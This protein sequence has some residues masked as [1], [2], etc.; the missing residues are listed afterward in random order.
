MAFLLLH[1]LDGSGPGHWQNWIAERLRGR[2]LEVAFPSLPDAGNPHVDRWLVALDEE[3]DR[4]PAAETTVLCHSL[5]C[6][7]WLHHAAAGPAEPV[8]RT[9][10]VAPTQPDVDDPQ[11]PGFRP[12]PLDRRAVAAAARETLLVCSTDDP[13]GPPDVARRIAATLEV[14]I[15]WLEHAGH[16]NAAG[17]YGPWPA[18][19]AWAVGERDSPVEEA[20]VP[21]SRQT[22]DLER[23]V[24]AQDRDGTYAR[25]AAE[26]RAG[27][28][29][30]HWMWF[31]FPQLDG[32]GR[33]PMAQAYA[34]S[35]LAEAQAYLDHPVLGTRLRE[36]A[37][38]LTGLAG[39]T[40][41]EI[42][43]E[44]DSVKLRSSMTLFARAD[45]AEPAFFEVLER[46]YGGAPDPATDR[47]LT[48]AEQPEP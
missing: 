28:K 18:L 3:L 48:V 37:R 20:V 15:G 38:I 31:V 17:G 43:G 16:V 24:Q 10:L 27:S 7:L 14:P 41:I 21:A 39:R 34:I 29:R 19:E 32:L 44:I 2:G 35:S 13:W 11:S 45:P 36:C 12:A 40:S 8:A 22:F 30:S 23:F 47:G 25:A 4:L 42:F 5:G 33:S 9:L 6:L 46:Y 1:G 26:L